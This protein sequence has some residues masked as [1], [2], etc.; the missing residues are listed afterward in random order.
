MSERDV[1]RM[2]SV[3]DRTVSNMTGVGVRMDP[4]TQNNWEITK[5]RF[6]LGRSGHNYSGC[7]DQAD[8]VRSVLEG[9]PWMDD[10]WSFENATAFVPNPTDDR[11]PIH[12]WFEGRSSNPDDPVVVVDPW[13]NKFDTHPEPATTPTP[14]PPDSNEVAGE[15]K[16]DIPPHVPGPSKC[17]CG[18]IHPEKGLFCP[19]CASEL[20]FTRG[21]KRLCPYCFRPV[22]SGA[23]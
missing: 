10:D 13:A 19:W 7:G 1:S 20:P 5:Y 2:K 8:F 23:Q 18:K 17:S 9:L 14:T 15:P 12:R 16:A 21:S 4:P 3:F 6:T 11:F 22:T